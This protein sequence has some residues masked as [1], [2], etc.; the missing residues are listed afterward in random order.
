MANDYGVDEYGRPMGMTQISPYR[1]TRQIRQGEPA[2]GSYSPMPTQQPPQPAPQPQPQQTRDQWRDAWMGAGGMTPQ[3]ADDWLRSHGATEVNSK[4][5]TWTTP[6]GDTLDLQIG[7]GAALAN[8]GMITPGWTPTGGG[9]GVPGGG[10]GGGGGVFGGMAGAG[11]NVLSGSF[12]GFNPYKAGTLPTT[13]LP[14]YRAGVAPQFQAPNDYGIEGKT[15]G[16]ISQF[17]GAPTY[18]P[19]TIAAMKEK[20]KEGFY[21]GYSDL[22]G[23]ARQNAISRGT[24]DSGTYGATE[25]DINARMIS[26]IL[27]GARDIDLGTI[28]E[29]RNALERGVGL[30]G[31]FLTGQSARA[32]ENFR[33]ALQ[34]VLSQEGLKQQEV[35]S[36]ADAV[37]FAL[38][39]ALQQEAL[40]QAEAG[41]SYQGAGLGLDMNRLSEMIRQFNSTMN[42]NYGRDAQQNNQWL[43]STLLGA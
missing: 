41:S 30:G 1:R 25:R 40:K 13:P 15:A 42:Y 14:T 4:N 31:T 6:Y 8:G 29:N 18:D 32:G 43:I 20:S 34:G 2:P 35:A 33:N 17:L 23:Q 10:G 37:R 39:Q 5:G 12:G 38:D 3:A 19:A 11:G 9:G 27:S 21:Q 28:A 16:I 7:R 26:D 24:F 36:G 22:M